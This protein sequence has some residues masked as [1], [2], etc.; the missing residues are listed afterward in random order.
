MVCQ[1]FINPEY[2]KSCE[3]WPRLELPV[4]RRCILGGGAILRGG[5]A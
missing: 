4:S 3:G 5:A 1:I 2:A